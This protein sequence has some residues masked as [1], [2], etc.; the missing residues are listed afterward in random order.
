MLQPRPISSLYF[1]RIEYDT[2]L[3]QGPVADAKRI[4]RLLHFVEAVY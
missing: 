4:D 1:A 2:L 3:V